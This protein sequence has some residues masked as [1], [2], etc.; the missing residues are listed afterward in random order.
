MTALAIADIENLPLPDNSVDMIFTDPP[1]LKAYLPCYEHLARQAMRVLKPGGF[2]L[3][4]C[5]GRTVPTDGVLCKGGKMTEDTDLLDYIVAAAVV[6][7]L[8]YL[9]WQ[10]WLR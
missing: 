2:V 1:Y 4:E 10:L 3:A 9:A 8:A 5:G 6:L 7:T